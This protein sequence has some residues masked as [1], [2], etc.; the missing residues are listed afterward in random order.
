M[1]TTYKAGTPHLGTTSHA[2]NKQT[3]IDDVVPKEQGSFDSFDHGVR[4]IRGPSNHFEF[5]KPSSLLTPM[6]S[7]DVIK[8]VQARSD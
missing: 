3:N 8:D 5:F 1:S 2:K 4:V 7:L 6:S